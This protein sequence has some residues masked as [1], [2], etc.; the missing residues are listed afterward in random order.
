MARRQQPVELADAALIEARYL[1]VDDRAHFKVG[2]DELRAIRAA[3]VRLCE[4]HGSRVAEALGLGGVDGGF[5][6]H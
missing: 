2:V 5:G 4:L 3:Q 1:T 6:D